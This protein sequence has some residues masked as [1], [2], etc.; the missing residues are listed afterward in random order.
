MDPLAVLPL[1]HCPNCGGELKIIAAILGQ[2][3]IEKNLTQLGLQARA[4]PRAPAR[5]QT[6]QAA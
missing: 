6:L 3:V 5:G 1:E 4:P 2:P